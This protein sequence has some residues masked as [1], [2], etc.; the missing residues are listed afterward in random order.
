MERPARDRR[1]YPR[2]ATT[3]MVA[4]ARVDDARRFAR[5][6]DL[7][8]GGIR[9]Q[10]VNLEIS[11]GELLR[12]TFTVDGEELDVLGRVA[13]ATEVDAFTTD[14]GLEFVEAEPRAFELLRGLDAA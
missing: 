6:H 10:V 4:V 3:Q 8:L 11:L 1:K 2:L 13:W 12:I 14:V 7:S 5:G 9:F